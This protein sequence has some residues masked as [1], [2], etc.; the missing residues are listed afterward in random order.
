MASAQMVKAL[1][2]LYG[3]ADKAHR[4]QAGKWLEEFQKSPEAWT[5][6]DLLLKQRDTQQEAKLFAAQTL[7]QKASRM[8]TGS[9]IAMIIY[10]LQDLD[11]TA[12]T[13]LRDS[14]LALLSQY[15]TGPKLVVTQLCLGIADLAL[16][17]TSWQ[18]VLT[19]MVNLY[20]KTPETAICL[21]EFLTILPEEINASSRIPMS[22]DVYQ[23]RSSELL[24]NNSDAVL[25]MLVMYMQTA[26]HSTDL[27]AKVFSCL[28][29]WLRTGDLDVNDL[30]ANPLL[31]LTF[32]SLAVPALFDVAVDVICEIIYQSKEVESYMQLIQQI[33]PLLQPL[34]DMLRQCS[35]DEDS[36]TVRGLCR[37]FTE[38]GESYLT[39]V[40]SHADAFI[41]I[42]DGIADCTAY[43]DLD[44]VPM[45][46]PFW[47]KLADALMNERNAGAVPKFEPVFSRLVDAII[48]HCHYPE[49]LS[50]WTAEERDEFR[51]FRHVMGDT[52]KDCCDVLGPEKCLAKPC[53]VL[54]RL[55]RSS[56]VSTPASSLPATPT[57]EQAPVTWQ[58]IE[59][60]IFALRAM[61][62]RVPTD[63]NT[64]MPQIM[65]LLQQLPPHPKIRYAATL[66]ISRY[67]RWTSYHPTYIPYQLQFVTA[68]FDDQEVAAA[69][70]LALKHLCEDCGKLL[71]GYLSELHPFYLNL[72]KS[73]PAKD[74]FEVTEAVAHVIAAVPIHEIAQA[75]QWF[76]LPSAQRLHEL[77]SKDANSSSE[78]EQKEIAD[79]IER[80]TLFLRIIRPDVPQAESHPCVAFL[81]EIWPV[82]ELVIANYGDNAKISESACRLFKHA[83]ITYELRL[84]PLLPNLMEQLASAFARSHLSCYLWIGMYVVREHGVRDMETAPACVSL[85]ENLS[86]STFSFLNGKE[87]RDVPDVIEDYFRLA[88]AVIEENPAPIV[89][90]NITSSIVQAGLAGISIEQANALESVLLFFRRILSVPF[91]KP[92]SRARTPVSTPSTPGEISNSGELRETPDAVLKPAVQSVF[93]VYG[94]DFCRL[95]FEGLI[96]HFPHEGVTDGAYLLRLLAELLPAETGQW[97]ITV[98]AEFPKA[99]LTT[100]ERETFLKAFATALHEHDYKK[101]YHRQHK[102]LYEY[103]TISVHQPLIG[104]ECVFVRAPPKIYP[105]RI[106]IQHW[107]LRDLLLC[108]DDKKLI[109]PC[110]NNVYQYNVTTKRVYRLLEDLSFKPTA[111]ACAHGYLAAGGHRSQLIV[112]D[113]NSTWAISTCVGGSINNSIAITPNPG[114]PEKIQMMVC[115]N[116]QTIKV[117]DLPIMQKQATIALPTAVNCASMSPDGRHMVAVGDTNQVFLYDVSK[118]GS[119]VRRHTF[120]GSRESSFSCSWNQRSEIFAV[121][122]QDG[123]V[124]VYDIKAM[125]KICELGTREQTYS[126]NATRCVKFSSSGSLDLLAYTEHESYIHIVDARTFNAQQSIRVAPDESSLD[127][128]ISG[129]SFTPDSRRLFVG[130][131]HA[132]HEYELDTVVRR[133]FAV[134]STI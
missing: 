111:L 40:L 124:N 58:A 62:A 120:T 98:I 71:V 26:G 7:R 11:E 96:D 20:G 91:T 23:Q 44:I 107:Q 42:V 38:A 30:A 122:S 29:S 28:L 9:L 80:I 86:A 1:E 81:T 102:S 84:R 63:E 74:A 116:D 72:M 39:L 64:L 17:F 78:A 50:T 121:A 31:P 114:Y 83:L 103:M 109:Y 56:A 22:D 57:T 105:L 119:Y 67:T 37:I 25:K 51:D 6:A 125:R 88:G 108:T 130:L 75:L 77:A 97:V 113:L 87:F 104:N 66:L 100:K 43:H 46:F 82:I 106:T 134:G 132:V 76:V 35:A 90:S 2:A 123:I 16:Q 118:S 79:V 68:G 129:L 65:D 19:D 85:F 49:D 101:L 27:Q 126:K 69:S 41:G 15:A 128:N 95:I 53:A 47:Y 133:S 73:L 92:F 110:D 70:A 117:Y 93:R 99:D 34:R 36:D 24:T 8:A 45:T 48:N 32:Q 12:R 61:G 4:E 13:S 14:L 60:P 21:L 5:T 115:N 18:N 52:L 54:T 59:A 112:R 55:L 89:Q 131:E 94:Y 33:Y 3:S 10:D 127:V